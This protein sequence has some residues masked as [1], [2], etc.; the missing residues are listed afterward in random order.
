MPKLSAPELI[1]SSLVWDNHG[2]MPLRPDDDSFLPQ[3]QRYFDAGFDVAFLNVAFDAMP[4]EQTVPQIALFR[5]WIQRHEDHLVQIKS[6]TDV[7]QAKDTGR[8]GICFDIEGGSAL[9]GNINMV[10]TYYELGV[11]WMLIAYNKNNLLGGGCQDDDSGLTEF[12]RQVVDEMARVGMVT[13]CSH[14]GY[15]TTMQV[16]EYA[17]NPVIFS[18]SNAKGVWDCPRNIR[19]EQI[20]A[21]A[22]TGGVIGINGI[23]SFLG[24]NDIRSETFVR[25]VDYVAEMVGPEH[26]GISL[27]YVFDPN[28]GADLMSAHPEYFTKEKKYVDT[29]LRTVP[30]EQLTEIVEGLIKLGYTDENLRLILGKNFL[31]IAKAVWK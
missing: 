18:H 17:Q 30:P 13:C 31:R 15:R 29:D 14:T 21:C 16:L 11:R 6:V 20:R 25:H 1:K 10:E 4:W 7:Q 19:D 8:L 9:N 23:G 5:S 3:L 12:G 27:D 24:D 22:D 2:C 28:E 26:V